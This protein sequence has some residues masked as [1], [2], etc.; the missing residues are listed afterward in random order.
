MPSRGEG[1][2]DLAHSQDGGGR[3]ED[4][5]GAWRVPVVKQG[6]RRLQRGLDSRP[7]SPCIFLERTCPT[8]SRAGGERRP[9]RFVDRASRAR[10]REAAVYAFSPSTRP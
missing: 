4:R 7:G 9:S 8:F 6:R 3:E 2:Q 10:A 1:E 5:T